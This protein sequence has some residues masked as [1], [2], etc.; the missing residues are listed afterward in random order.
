MSMPGKPYDD[1][2]LRSLEIWLTNAPPK[3]RALRTAKLRASFRRYF[4][5]SQRQCGSSGSGHGRN[6]RRDHLLADKYFYSNVFRHFMR[7]AAFNASLRNHHAAEARVDRSAAR[8]LG[9]AGKVH[10][11]HDSPN[12]VSLYFGA[13][14]EFAMRR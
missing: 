3:E 13:R 2:A 11:R 9:W 5:R 14:V 1:S 8:L 12:G 4:N 10:T 6:K 7:L